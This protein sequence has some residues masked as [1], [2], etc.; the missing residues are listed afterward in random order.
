[1]IRGEEPTEYVWRAPDTRLENTTPPPVIL[2][3]GPLTVEVTPP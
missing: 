2:A 1:M 3:P